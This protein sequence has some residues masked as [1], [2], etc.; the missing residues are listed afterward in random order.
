MQSITARVDV[1]R[2]K[3]S[4]CFVT[5]SRS[6]LQLIAGEQLSIA[7]GAEVQM[8]QM[9]RYLT[10]RGWAVSFTVHDIGQKGEIV[11]SEGIR[12]IKAYRHDGGIPGMRR[13]T[14]KL[15]RLWAALARADAQIY[16]VRGV[17]WINGIVMLFSRVKRRHTVIWMANENDPLWGQKAHRF[18]VNNSPPGRIDAILNNYAM[19]NCDAVVA[20]TK[21]QCEVLL[22]ARG[23]HAVVI[24]NIWPLLNDESTQSREGVLWVGNFRPVKRP[25]WVLKLAK[26][27]RDVQFV[28]IGGPKTGHED[29][30]EQCERRANT[31]P[32][33]DF[34][35]PLPFQET[36]EYF[37]RAAVVVLTSESEGFPNVLL[38]AWAHGTPTVSTFDP[39]GIIQEHGLGFYC[40]TIDELAE[41][42]WT[43]IRN[44]QLREE[45]GQRAWEYVR[46]Y[47]APEVVLPMVE[48]LFLSLLEG[49]R[50][51]R[52][53]EVQSSS[54]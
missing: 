19:R 49:E 50:V 45:I 52:E 24:P 26:R 6:P 48:R 31:L 42:V 13:L 10:K 47:H 22:E 5:R 30:Y 34:K 39:D 38:Q 41:S 1:L 8:A 4:V 12:L 44:P 20:Q 27:L 18:D 7:G 2:M 28:V 3:P 15:P 14:H 17:S 11:S 21:R 46:K 35:G 33:V 37:G 23:R 53:A 40:Q 36:D 9:A 51:Q 25:D 29:L 54:S 16:V 43:L 32:N